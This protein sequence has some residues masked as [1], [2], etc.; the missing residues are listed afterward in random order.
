MHGAGHWTAFAAT[1]Q[2]STIVVQ[3]EVTRLD[4]ADVCRVIDREG[5][6]YLQVIGDAFVRP[7][8]EEM[9]AGSYDLS[10]LRIVLSG[11]AALTPP[12]KSRLLARLPHLAIV[13]A[14]RVVGGRRPGLADDHV[15]WPCHHRHLQPARG[16]GRRVRRP[17]QDPRPR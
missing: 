10:S 12:L 13:E 6:T 9:E 11:G 16:V 1:N 17:Q 5:V 8:L 2:G 7:I 4:P 14:R 15:G 3:D